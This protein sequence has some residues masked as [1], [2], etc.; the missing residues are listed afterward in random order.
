MPPPHYNV[1]EC[2]DGKWLSLG[3]LEPQFWAALCRLVGREDMIERQSDVSAWPA[4]EEHLDGFFRRKPRDEWF[5]ELRDVEL[6]IAPVLDLG[7]A[8]GNEHQQARGMTVS[9]EDASLGTVQHVGVG[10]KFSATPASVRST[11]PRPGEH[12]DEVLR[13]LGR[14]AEQIAALREADV[15][16]G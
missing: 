13:A 6:C 7:E 11:A 1:Y 12:T 15:V 8:L 2:A 16:G 3:S 4:F 5:A 9:V 14:D 10:P